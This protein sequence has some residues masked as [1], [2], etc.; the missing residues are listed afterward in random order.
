MAVP[1]IKARTVAW[2]FLTEVICRHGTPSYLHSD[3]GTNY[4]SHIVKET[5]KLLQITKTQTSSYHPQCNGQSERM[6]SVI[7]ASLAKRLDAQHDTWDR[8]LPF[9]QFVHNNSPC[10]DSTGYSPAFLTYGLHPRSPLDTMLPA[11]DTM[12]PA[13]PD[14]PRSAQQYLADLLS[15][16]ECA[17]AD[18]EAAMTAR[19]QFMMAKG[20]Q[21]AH[22]PLFQVGEEVFLYSPVLDM[23]NKQSAKLLSP[24]TGPYY[25]VEK[26]SAVNVRLRRKSDNVLVAGPIHINRLKPAVTRYLDAEMKLAGHSQQADT[27]SQSSTVSAQSELKSSNGSDTSNM[28]GTGTATD[29]TQLYDMDRVDQTVDNIDTPQD[30]SDNQPQS[31]VYYEIEKIVAK[32]CAADDQWEYRVKWVNFPAKDNSWVKFADLNPSCQRY[33]TNVGNK[34]PVYS[35]KSKQPKLSK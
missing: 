1:D 6:M 22:D 31:N 2:A 14:P 8:H 26:L 25:I 10:L 15:V 21:I 13:I 29:S 11:L 4:L 30:V 9:V 24:W 19:K 28:P 34:I 3:R 18:A 20:Q 5:C 16:L 32:R 7:L 35:G 23:Q 17:K 12:L 27:L 33:V